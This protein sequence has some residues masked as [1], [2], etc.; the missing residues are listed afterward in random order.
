M[1]VVINS[2]EARNLTRVATPSG[3]VPDPTLKRFVTF[4]TDHGSVHTVIV[5]ADH[6]AQDAETLLKWFEHTRAGVE[7]SSNRTTSPYFKTAEQVIADADKALGFVSGDSQSQSTTTG[8][9]GSG[10]SS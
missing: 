7:L 6:A 9:Q 10:V 1:S 8:G 5:D 4:L 2:G 3:W